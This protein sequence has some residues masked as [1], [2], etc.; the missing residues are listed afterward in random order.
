MPWLTKVDLNVHLEAEAVAP[1][2]PTSPLSKKLPTN[3]AALRKKLHPLAA[4]PHGAALWKVDPPCQ[5]DPTE[6]IA[7]FSK[8]RMM[9]PLRSLQFRSWEDMMAQTI[10]PEKSKGHRLPGW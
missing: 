5:A 7:P 2:E 8:G 9:P 3:H 4:S 1:D 10:F 6:L